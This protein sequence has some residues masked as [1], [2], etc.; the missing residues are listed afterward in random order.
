VTRERWQR[1]KEVFQAVA[2]HAPAEREACLAAET[3]GDGELRHEVERMLRYVTGNGTLDKPAWDSLPLG[4]ELEAGAHLGPYAILEKVGAG[5]MGRVYKARDTR[6]DRTVAIKVLSDEFSHRLR[7]E[8]RAISALNHPHVCALYDIG[9]QDGT[10]YLVMEY[11]EGESLAACLS[12]GPLPVEAV[13]RYGAEIAGALA[14]AHFHGI[15]HRDLKPANIMITAAGAKVL[16]FGVARMAEDEETTAGSLVGTAA[17]MSPSQLNGSPAEARSDI[18]ALGLVLSEMATGARPDRNSPVALEGVPSGLAALIERCLRQDAASRLQ[19]MDD[20]RITLERLRAELTQGAGRRRAKRAWI[21]R[22]VATGAAAAVLTWKVTAPGPR[23]LET[24][25]PVATIQ[26][27]DDRGLAP[28]RKPP[29]QPSPA[30]VPPT[31]SSPIASPPPIVKRVSLAPPSLAPLVKYPGLERD[32]S[33]SPDGT[34]VAFAWHRDRPG[35]GIS[36]GPVDQDVARTNLT[37]GVFED[38][39]PSWSPDGRKIAFQ[40][41]TGQSGI[42]W[43]GSS[44]G[45][46]NLV[47]PIARPR[48]ETLPQVSWSHDGKWIAAP[49][50]DSDGATELYLFPVGSGE[51]RAV[52]SNTNGTDHAPAFSPNGKSLAYASCPKGVSPCDVYVIDFDR[53]LVPT[54]TRRITDQ[55]VYIRGIAWLPDGRSLVYSAGRTT[56]QDTSLWRVAVNPP[57]LP[58]RID[59]AGSR[60]RHPATSAT[61]GLLAYTRLDNWSLMMI[62]NFR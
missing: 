3:S 42:Y 31:T 41:R 60:A 57:G 11:V 16:D 14:A 61:G 58:E 1:I 10:A 29:M 8:A 23:R 4:N 49:D 27:S 59:L 35:Y 45:D 44:G 62:K 21:T 15:V 54:G 5:G 55:G 52:T 37:N 48:Q 19:S 9:D 12:R 22:L 17:Y 40:R 6:L 53:N 47:A 51:K 28:I 30:P 32:P 2:E 18:F 24:R 26:S 56:S 25:P 46:E 13:L 43:V 33:F 38:W 20:V 50:R 34:K 39:G 36:V 7:S